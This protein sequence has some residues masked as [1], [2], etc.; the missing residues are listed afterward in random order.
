[1]GRENSYLAQ[2][3]T[4]EHDEIAFWWNLAKKEYVW[5]HDRNKT[6]V[7]KQEVPTI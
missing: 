3:A 2:Q 1:M 7:K 4:M 5:P 6:Y